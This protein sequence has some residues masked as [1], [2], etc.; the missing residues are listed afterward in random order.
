MTSLNALGF[1]ISLLNVSSAQR[2]LQ[3]DPTWEGT[4]VAVTELLDDPT[5]AHAWVGV[6]S[7]WPPVGRS[8]SPSE[9]S[10][11]VPASSR[12]SAMS[13]NGEALSGQWNLSTTPETTKNAIKSACEAV[14]Q[15]ERAITEFD[16]VLGD[17]DCG[18]TFSTGAKGMHTA[19]SEVMFC[20]RPLPSNYQIFEQHRRGKNEPPP[21]RWRTCECIGGQYWRHNR[22]LSVVNA[23]Y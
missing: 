17:G 4:P 14:L 5:D 19:L 21:T 15:A 3:N 8:W 18:E 10:P 16:T 22:C 12:R 23:I 2:M 1:S 7:C 20:S 9:N 13:V 6:R 11:D